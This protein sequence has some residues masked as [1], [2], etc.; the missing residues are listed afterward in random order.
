MRRLVRENALCALAAG[1]ASATMGWLGLYGFGWNDYETEAQPAFGVLTHGHVL[2]FL[3]LAPAYGGSLVERAP[4][5]LL[6]GLWGGGQLAV[7]RM[8]A[9]PCLLAAA[10]LGVWLCARMRAAGRP[11]LWQAVVLGVCVLNPLTLQALEL[12]HPEELLGAC[13][14][15][16][17]VLVASRDRP[18]WAGV[19][20]GLAIANKEWALIAAGPVLLALPGS[21]TGPDDRAG[22]RVRVWALAGRR[23]IRLLVS[24][25]TMTAIVLAPLV[26]AS[27][28]GFSG[29]AQAVAV[30][31]GTL[32]QPWQI[33]WFLGWHGPLVHRFGVAMPGYRTGPAWTG[34][35]SHPLIVVVGLG[36]AG[37]LWLQRRR[38]T[39]TGAIGER[40]ALLMLALVL[41]LRCLLDTWDIG[42]YMLPCLI[43]LV[44]WEALGESRR[45]PILA[46]AGIV[47][48]WLGL[49]AL[50]A[51][52][53]SPDQ[54]AALFLAWTLPLCAGLALRLYAPTV[55]ANQPS[56]GE[57]RA[58]PAGISDTSE[59][60]PAPSPAGIALEQR[61][62]QEMT[63]SSLG[64][65]VS[66]S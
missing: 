57:M 56:A 23:Q 3:R 52:G 41:L 17:A 37:A 32:F 21:A 9:L 44:S 30:A 40:D 47:I 12:G 26:L 2:E 45:P 49:K 14:C 61:A 54:Q 16:A 31:P 39:G 27:G 60:P 6:P 48:P 11:P 24:T 19:L 4:F 20:L 34:T 55:L 10:A 1:A 13:L 35:I 36:L 46:L 51:H 18:L 15:V 65:P 8:V 53:A 33:W 38:R 66:T 22:S 64:S 58:R 62:A 5:A 25:G 29:S 43:A 28:G 59:L 63:V 42:Y 7:Y 50:S